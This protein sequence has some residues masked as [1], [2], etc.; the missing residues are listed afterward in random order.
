MLPGY[1]A[2]GK[3]L[4]RYV[5]QT[6]TDPKIAILYQND[7]LGKDFVAGFKAGLGDRV[8]ALVVSE[9]TFEVSDPTISSQ[10]VSAK[11]SGANVFFFAGTQKFGAM[12]IRT[13]LRIGLETIASRLQHFVGS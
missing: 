1:D 2:E 3:A 5:V 10:V 4:A 11:A 6:V 7:D 9:Q 12:Q 8:K 13:R